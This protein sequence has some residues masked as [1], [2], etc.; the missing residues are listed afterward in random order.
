MAYQSKHKKSSATQLRI[1]GV[2]LDGLSLR[3]FDKAV[4]INSALSAELTKLAEVLSPD[5]F[6]LRR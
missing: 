1:D 4:L 2:P 6:M 5:L 3:E